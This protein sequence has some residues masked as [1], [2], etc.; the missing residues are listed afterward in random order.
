M[1][2]GIRFVISRPIGR[3]TTKVQS[4]LFDEKYWTI[5]KAK[6]WLKR[7]RLHAPAPD[8]PEGRGHYLRFRQVDPEKFQ[9]KYFRTIALPHDYESRPKAPRR[10]RNSRKRN[11]IKKKAH[12]NYYIVHGKE[13]S[14]YFDGLEF[15]RDK[16]Q[17]VVFHSQHAAEKLAHSIAN[18][19]GLAVGVKPETSRYKNPIGVGKEQ[20][21]KEAA[22]HYEAFHGEQPNNIDVFDVEPFDV[23]YLL[24]HCDGVLYTTTRHGRKEKYIHEFKPRSRPL[25]A[26]SYDGKELLVLGGAYEVTHRGIV[27][28]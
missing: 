12:T 2:K 25:L 18:K 10:R 19:I 6:A 11:T 27:D 20:R 9:K 4:V 13:Q 15:T 8:K 22:E 26:A 21:V 3:R 16:H 28:R 7:N 5:A 14:K 1:I 24:G 17:A 23:A